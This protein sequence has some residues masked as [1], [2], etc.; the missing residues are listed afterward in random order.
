MSK[1][2]KHLCLCCGGRRIKEC[3]RPKIS[4]GAEG[5]TH[6]T[7]LA[8]RKDVESLAAAG[9]HLEAIEILEKLLAG[10]PRNPLI[11]NDLGVQYEA[12]GEIDKAFDALRRGHA[13]D[14]T[15]PPTLYNL[16][17]FTLAR[18]MSLE[19]VVLG[20]EVEGQRMLEEAISFLNAYLDRDPDNAD[21]HYY[22]ALAYDLNQ[23]EQMAAAHMTVT[24]RL[25]QALELLQTVR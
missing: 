13:I 10:S 3:C 2:T 15:Y 11:W 21:G 16:G 20:A 17:K 5:T 7:K 18:F 8:M 22:L 25:R 9:R 19:K 4:P 23:D 1:K 14:P 6:C 24:L 12:I